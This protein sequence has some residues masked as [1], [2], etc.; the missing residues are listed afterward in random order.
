MEQQTK[1]CQNCK[2]NF[3]I[4]SEDFLFYEKIKVP[5][6]TFCPECRLVRRLLWINAR[7]LYSRKIG[8][9][10]KKFISMYSEDKPF[11]IVEDKNWWSDKIDML[12]YCVNYDFSKSFF[13][14]YKEL[15]LRASLPHLQRAYTTMINSDYCNAVAGLK[16]C[17]LVFMSDQSE[18][19]M[20]SHTVE[21][22]KDCLDMIFSNKDELC[23]DGINLTNCYKCLF[24]DVCED[25]SELIFCKNCTG[26][27]NCFGSI[28]LRNKQYYIFNKLYSKEEYFEKLKEFN[29]RSFEDF[30]KIKEKVKNFFMENPRKFMQ[31]RKNSD[32]LGDYIYQSKNAKSVFTCGKVEDSKY[33]HF[34]RYVTNG[35]TDSYDYTI[36]GVGADLIYECAWCGID[37]SNLK[38]SFWNYGSQNLEY[39]FGCHSSKNL[40]GCIGLRNKQYCILNKQYSK[41][42]YESLIPKIKE[43]MNSM[44]YI[45]KKG[46][47]YKYGEFFPSELSPF[48]YNETTAEEYFPL[49]KEEVQ[50]AGLKWK[51]REERNYQIT[52]KTEDIPDNI[53]DVP[54][55]ITKEIIECS[56]PIGSTYGVR[57]ATNC[58]TAFKILPNEL[59]FYKKMNIP[60]PRLCPNCRYSERIKQRNP[61]KLWKRK[62]GCAGE[63]SDN[64]IYKNTSKHFHENEHC[65]NEFETTYSPDRKE[66]VYC[67]ACYNSEVA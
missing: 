8:N 57:E 60:L 27:S 21:N 54:D 53:K 11:N 10:D 52:L 65:L 15:M 26:C 16:N 23:Y 38:F 5:P 4:D 28:N 47:I 55:T 45:D 67:E 56:Y 35:T 13:L 25:S 24:C 22:L 36:F 33:C 6:P 66:I 43:H 29:L 49:T 40:F 62:C 46:N 59:E 42:E 44:P 50:K 63:K 37:I 9:S 7:N 2:Q 17:Y 51:E 64:S 3:V 39:C 61:L 20:Y 30:Q 19:T 34:L 18:N 32:V 1:Q 48:G 12:S 31:G 41:E 14:Q 58:S